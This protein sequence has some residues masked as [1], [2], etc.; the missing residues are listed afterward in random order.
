MDR[1]DERIA[2]DEKGATA[3][4]YGLIVA[5]IVLAL[6]GGASSLGT[7]SGGMWGNMTDKVVNAG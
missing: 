6:V 5:L 2:R 1:K 3:I 7:S 4:E